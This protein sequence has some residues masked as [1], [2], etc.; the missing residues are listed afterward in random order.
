MNRFE[1]FHQIM[2]DSDL[3]SMR[4][5]VGSMLSAMIRYF[6][7]ER[8]GYFTIGAGGMRCVLAI[9]RNGVQI[10]QPEKQLPVDMFKRVIATGSPLNGEMPL[11]GSSGSSTASV[12]G[13]VRIVR[14]LVVP[15]FAANHITGLCYLERRFQQPAFSKQQESDL[16]GLME[17]MQ[18]LLVSSSDY[19][20]KSFE[21]DTIKS[22]VAMSQVHLISQNPNMLK[23]FRYIQKLAKVP[24]TVLIWGESGTG[25]ELVA[26]AIYELGNYEGPFISMNCG[27]IEPNLMKSELFGYLKGSFTG[28]GKDRPGLFKKA[29]N[30]V[31]FM[32]EI[33]EMPQDMQVAMLRTLECG[34]ILPVG[35]DTPIRVN[36]RVV[37]A[38]H[39]NLHEMVAEGTFRND[40][41]Q[42]LKGLTLHVPPL[43]ERRSDIPLLCKHF[44]KKYNE[45][46]GVNFK[47]ISQKAMEALTNREFRAGN[48]RELEHM[49]ERAMVFEDNEETISAGFL[50]M[51]EQNAP[52]PE[53]P[54]NTG[55]GTFEER[56]NRYAAQIL[57]ETIQATGG[58]KS[59]AMKQLD[60]SR[61]AFYDMLHRHG[62]M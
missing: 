21:L 40:L 54:P 3:T 10:S 41:Y 7:A 46:L 39:R 60:L 42:R 22:R 34:E 13:K 6:D 45:R 50:F 43:R 31:L 28:A 49:I 62:L 16:L 17:D 4:S 57:E 25:K 55:T 15:G 37:A 35:S 14:M 18:K 36:T 51:D 27:G 8:G 38:T 24:S 52:E 2:M 58:N 47:G 59:K 56:M 1:L 29:Q 19:E 33:G 20:K 30:G 53:M 11:I 9:G 61:S 32:D 23:L 26:R 44:L 5:I 12:T 48:V